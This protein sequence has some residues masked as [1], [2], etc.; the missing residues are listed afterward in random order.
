MMHSAIE[1]LYKDKNFNFEKF[2]DDYKFPEIIKIDEQEILKSYAAVILENYVQYYKKDFQEMRFEAVEESFDF[3]YKGFRMLG[4]IDGR[5]KDKNNG[6]WHIEHKNYRQIGE[7]TMILRLSFD[8]Q[9]LF[10]LLMDRV[11]NKRQL[12]GVIYNVIRK[13]D[14]RKLKNPSEIYEY[15]SN[16]I[17]KNPEHYFVRFE[18]PYTKDSLDQFEKELL[19]KLDELSRLITEVKNGRNILE[20]FYKNECACTIPYTCSFL[21]ACASGNMCQYKQHKNLFEEV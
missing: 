9:N 18:I 15:L 10:Y 8:L 21:N 3:E 17:K 7:E 19:Y 16:E 2:I 11:Q 1:N 14:V 4:K 13:P 5:F 6:L 12:H 20:V